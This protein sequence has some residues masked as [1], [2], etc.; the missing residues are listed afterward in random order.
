MEIIKTIEE[1]ID[2]FAIKGRLDTT[3]ANTLEQEII[4]F[5]QKSDSK[6]ILECKDLEY[7]SSSGLRVV[8]MAHKSIAGKG[9]YFAIRNLSNEVKTVFDMTGFSKILNIL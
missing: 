8:L 4:P 5:N 6:L 2:V 3:T 1:G 9:G 7:V